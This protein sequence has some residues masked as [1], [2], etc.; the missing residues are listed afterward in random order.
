[1]K[2][3]FAI[4]SAVLLAGCSVFGIRDRTEEPEYA[5]LDQ[6]GEVEIRR[7][8]ER[9]A[10]DVV[11]R[12]AAEE[13]LNEGFRKLADFI[14]GNNTPEQEISMT[15]PVEQAAESIGM[16]AP[17]S[18]EALENGTWRVRFFMPATYTIDTLPR[19]KSPDIEV[20]TVPSETYAVLKFT[21]RRDSQAFSERRTSLLSDLASSAWRPV[22]QAKNWYFD[23]PWTIPWLRRNEVAVPVAR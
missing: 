11:V 8:R 14:F 13:A 21:G 3:L 19:P 22:G 16:T 1:M 5:V 2:Q 17:V 10:A 20:V 6:I 18:Q 9:L 12:G 4:L 15:T 7:Y 23:P